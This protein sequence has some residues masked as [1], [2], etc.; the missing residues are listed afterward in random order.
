[1]EYDKLK[2]SLMQ[3]IV[4]QAFTYEELEQIRDKIIEI[5]SKDKSVIANKGI[6]EFTEKELNAMPKDIKRLL[7]LDKKRCHLRTRPSGQNS[8]TYE[9]RFRRDGYNIT[10]TGKTIELAKAKFL[11]KCK[12]AENQTEQSLSNTPTKFDDFAQFYF[13]TFRAEKVAAATLKTDK[14]RYNA[15]LRPY[16]KQVQIKNITPTDCKKLLDSVKVQGK[17]KTADELHSLMNVIFKSAIAHGIID[18]NPLDIVLHT[19]HE[20]KSGKALTRIEEINLKSALENT[21][22]LNAIMILLYTGLRPNELQ[23]AKIQ[24]EFIIAENSKRKNKK[25]S[26]KKIPII[27]ALKPYLIEPLEFASLETLRRYFNKA[28]PNHILYDLRTTFYTRCDEYNVSA[29]ARDEFV[30]HSN[31]ALTN[32]YRNL[33]NEYLLEESKKLDKWE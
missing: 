32:A 12:A 18:R 14:L 29:A 25:I 19:Q 27:K 17:G 28:L 16:F 33:S 6:V 5:Q 3:E 7:L 15:Y 23:T 9:I 4:S 24:G 31:G 13:T 20:R 21:K 11:E 1:M 26:Y 10:A 8:V 22:H 2:I 30:G